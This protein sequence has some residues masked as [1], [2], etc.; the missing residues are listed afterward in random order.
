MDG[1]VITL[2][3]LQSLVISADK[4]NKLS[5]SLLCWCIFKHYSMPIVYHQHEM[6]I[7]ISTK[8]LDLE[9]TDAITEVNLSVLIRILVE[10]DFNTM[11]ISI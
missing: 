3:S 11:R 5:Q 7:I 8:H 4:E 6:F 1:I 9:L 2:V 10:S